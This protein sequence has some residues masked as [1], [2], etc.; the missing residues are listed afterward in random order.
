MDVQGTHVDTGRERGGRDEPGGCARR[1]HVPAT[2]YS[3]RRMRTHPTAQLGRLSS[4]LCG[5]LNAAE[6]QKRGIRVYV[7]LIQLAVHSTN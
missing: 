7:P 5:D 2:T 1:T 3:S 6:I 4:R